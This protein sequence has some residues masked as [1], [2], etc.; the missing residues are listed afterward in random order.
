LQSQ[1]TG[2]ESLRLYRCSTEPC[3]E[4]S[5]WIDT[6]IDGTLQANPWYPARLAWQGLVEELGVYAIFLLDT[7]GDGL[8]DELDNCPSIANPAQADADN[9]GIGD[10]CDPCMDI[11]GDGFGNPGFPSN[12]CPLDNCPLIANPTQADTD[13][14][15]LGDACDNC[16]GVVNLSQADDDGDGIGDACDANPVF[17]V[18]NDPGDDPD[19]NTIQAAVD[20]VVQSGTLIRVLPGL[21]PYLEDVVVDA[22]LQIVFE[23]YDPEALLRGATPV[24]VDGG[25]QAAFTVLSTSGTGPIRFAGLTLRGDGGIATTIGLA[26]RDVIFEGVTGVAIDIV[27][28]THRVE[29]AAFDA[30]VHDAI[31]VAAGASLELRR[32]RIEGIS[33]T[34]LQADGTALL[35]NVLIA[36]AGAGVVLGATGSVTLLHVTLTDATGAGIDRSAGGTATMQHTIVYGNVGGDLVNVPCTSVSWSLIGS[37]DCTGINDNVQADPQFIGGGD[38]HL[39]PGSA[40]LDHGPH[41]SSFTGVP[42]FDLD[43]NPRQL[44][45]D[46]DGLAVRDIGAYEHRGSSLSP[47]AVS[48][49]RWPTETRLTWDV[50]PDATEYHVYRDALTT[51]GY[52]DFGTCRDDLDPN[53]TD[54]QL[55]DFDEPDPGAGFFY[56]VTAED[57]LGS[58]GSAGEASCTEHSR[59]AP[60]P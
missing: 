43:G 50:E 32:S 17:V 16:P 53:R 27:G 46:G 55:D 10:A 18:S 40:A 6:G 37:V 12:T 19:F 2:G 36:E 30:T 38:W 8:R 52:G 26:L 15:A 7:D 47:A 35:E 5:S 57:A 39:S 41:P 44:D 13:A 60:C 20:A 45:H 51:L 54:E 42:C 33:G 59:F 48:N 24:V 9:D 22:G 31:A 56:L 4:A 49:L 58:E 25:G 29:G 34:A 1:L 14:D 21:G 28:G 23:G 11:D 3:A